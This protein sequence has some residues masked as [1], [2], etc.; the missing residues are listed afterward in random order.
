MDWLYLAVVMLL[1]ALSFSTT[2]EWA[3]RKLVQ[4][5]FYANQVGGRDVLCAITDFKKVVPGN[6]P[7]KMTMV[8]E[9]ITIPKGALWWVGSRFPWTLNED[10]FVPFASGGLM[11]TDAQRAFFMP[12]PLDNLAEFL[13]AKNQEAFVADPMLRLAR[14]WNNDLSKLHQV[15]YVLSGI[16]IMLAGITLAL[17]A[18]R[19]ETFLATDDTG[20]KEYS[21][22]GSVITDGSTGFLSLGKVISVQPVARDV[23]IVC[24]KYAH[25][26]GVSLCTTSSLTHHIGDAVYIRSLSV[27]TG[28]ENK[29]VLQEL[30]F[31]VSKAE[32]DALVATGKYR[33]Q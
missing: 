13:E 9:T 22:R 31:L 30:T 20:V 26:R 21:T 14:F 16:A 33:V 8:P 25:A 19:Q 32:A 27:L 28:E 18:T 3:K 1:I 7:R 2:T 10:L 29:R 4:P 24:T 15:F 5:R 23:S 6:A 11:S 17:D 12:Q